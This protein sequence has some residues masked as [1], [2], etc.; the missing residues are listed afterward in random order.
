MRR[1]AYSFKLQPLVFIYRQ[2]ADEPAAH[3][4]DAAHALAQ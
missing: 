2:Q 4:G 3:H 1:L